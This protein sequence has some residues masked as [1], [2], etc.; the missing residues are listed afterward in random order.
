MGLLATPEVFA[1]MMLS[2]KSGTIVRVTTRNPQDS[3]RRRLTRYGAVV[4]AVKSQG[5]TSLQCLQ[6]IKTPHGF[7]SSTR[8]F[9]VFDT[10]LETLSLLA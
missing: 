4:R 5:R 2:L 1:Q 8:S 6:V 9:T 10:Q 3:S 7:S